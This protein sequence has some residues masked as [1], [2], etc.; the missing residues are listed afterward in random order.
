MPDTEIERK[1]LAIHPTLRSYYATDA[2]RQP[3]V[4]GLFDRASS[5]YDWLDRVLSLGSGPWYRAEVLRRAGLRPG[6]SV[7]DVATGTGPVA[8]TARR[9]VG[10]GGVVVGVDPSRG[11]L[12]VAKEKV[13]ARFVQALGEALAV[14]SDAFDLLTMGYALRHVGDLREAF[15]EY[16]RVLKPGGQ[17]VI[18]EL[19]V[20]RSRLGAGLLRGYMSKVVPFVVR[21]G[22]RNSDAER[23]MRYYWDTT[24][25]CAS[26]EVIMETLRATGFRDVRR[27]V[28][29][30]MLTEYV[31]MK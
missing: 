9:M 20:P 28:Q 14:R 18:M 2:E 5:H 4:S 16:H 1:P 12:N 30:G 3:F 24:A 23:L 21:L 10:A 8:A 19:C 27:K 6:M 22:T 11:M 7:L 15:R 31:A 26:P 29:W 17:V 13:D 25:S